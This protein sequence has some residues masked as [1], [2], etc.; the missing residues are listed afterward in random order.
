MENS[1]AILDQSIVLLFG[2]A[3]HILA[4]DKSIV[5]NYFIP[6][7][8][9]SDN[10]GVTKCFDQYLFREDDLTVLSRLASGPNCT[11]GYAIAFRCYGCLLQKCHLG[12]FLAS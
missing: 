7:G 6:L 12:K 2:I 3:F 5:N 10:Q 4:Q 8:K 9:L 1:D 11:I